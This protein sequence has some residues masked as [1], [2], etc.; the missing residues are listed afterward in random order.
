MGDLKRRVDR[1]E[2]ATR[3]PDDS[4]CIVLLWSDGATVDGET[5]DYAEYHRRW[6]EGPGAAAYVRRL[7]FCGKDD[8]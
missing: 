7:L 2:A 5:M 4:P 6:P 1:L 3:P 8:L